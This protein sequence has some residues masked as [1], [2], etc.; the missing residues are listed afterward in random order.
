MPLP[1]STRSFF[2]SS[3]KASAACA[4]ALLTAIGQAQ[5]NVC[6]NPGG[7]GTVTATGTVNTYWTPGNGTYNNASSSIPISSP[8]GASTGVALAGGD[9]V[10]LIQMQCAN[11]NTSDTS[12]YGDGNGS[13]TE[14]GS[15]LARGYTDPAGSCLAGNY[16]FVRAGSASTAASLDI[17]AETLMHTYVQANATTTTG[18]RTF[19][20]I[21]VPQYDNLTISGTVTAP[22]WNAFTGGVVAVDVATTMT[23]NGTIDVDG[24]GF[25]GAYGRARS[26]N[27][28]T[29]RYVRTD[30]AVHGVKGEGIAGTP[31]W[32]STK[33]TPDD[34][35]AAGVTDQG[36]GW[37]GYPSGSTTTGDYARGAPGNAG[38]GGNF[39]NGSSD[40]GGGGG[41]G[42]GGTGGRGGA[43]W[44]SAGYGGINAN[45]SNLAEQKWG[46][47][48]AQFSSASLARLVFGG[49]GGA[50]DN[51]NN[52]SPANSAGAAGGGIVIIHTRRLA[53]TG[54][55]S[56]R[57]GRAADNPLNDGGG[58]GGAGGSVAL[59]AVELAGGSAISVNAQGGRGANAHFDGGPANLN[60]HGTGG[61]GGGGVVVRTVAATVDVSGGTHGLTENSDGGPDGQRHGARAGNTGLN[62]L[63]TVA[64]DTTT[65]N[66][67]YRCL[68]YGDAPAS[69]GF[70]R[71]NL[72]PSPATLRIGSVTPDGDASAESALSSSNALID[73]TSG[74]NDES[75]VSFPGS[76]TASGVYTVTVPFTN[77]TGVAATVC[78]WV[79]FDKNGTFDTDERACGT[80]SSGGTS[81]AL[82]FIVPI[83]DRGNTGTFF[84]RFRL[85]NLSTQ[86][87]SPTGLASSGEVEDYQISITTLPVTLASVSSK[88]TGDSVRVEWTTA[89]ETRNAGFHIYGRGA[90]QTDWYR[91]TDDLIPSP[92]IDSLDPQRYVW[93]AQDLGSQELLIEDWDSRGTAREHGPF[94]I[95]QRYGQD[96]DEAAAKID[97]AAIRFKNSRELEERVAQAGAAKGLG[98]EVVLWVAQPGI[99]RVTF[100]DLAAAGVRLGESKVQELAVT[101]NGQPVVRFVD[102]ANR[103]GV[104]DSGDSVEFVGRVTP[105]L[106]SNR[107]A[108]RLEPSTDKVR[109][110][111][112]RQ[113]SARWVETSVFDHRVTVEQQRTYTFAAPGADPWYDERLLATSSPV[114]LERTF[115]LPGYAGGDAELSIAVW[116]LT[117]WEGR[118]DHHLIVEVAGVEVADVRFDG[119]SSPI[120][121]AKIPA[122]LLS[123]SNN[124]L[125]LRVP[126]DTGFPYD[127]QALD[128]FWIDYSRFSEAYAGEWQGTVNT[129]DPVLV[130]G[131][132]AGDAVAWNGAQR[133]TGAREIVVS[134][135]GL[136]IAADSEGIRR[137]EVALHYKSTALPARGSVDYLIIS[138]H[139]FLNS[140]S[141]RALV[142]LQ[143]S[144]GYGTSVVD[145]AGIYAAYSDFEADAGAIRRAI[146]TVQPKY[147]LLV[148]A[149]SFDY[150]DYL[151]LGSQS[152]VPTQYVRTG[153]VVTYAPADNM[154]ADFNDDGIPEVAIG[155]LP[156]RTSDEL[157]RLVSKLRTWLPPVQ[158]VFAS[159]PSDAARQLA[160]A[161]ESFAE[162][163][164][165]ALSVVPVAVDDLG[166]DL[167]RSVLL[168]ELDQE[169][170]L[171]SYVGHS[172][173]GIWGLNPNSGILLKTEDVRGAWNP[174]PHLVTQWGCWNTYFVDPR[175]DTLAN[176]FLLQESGAAAVM[177]ATALTNSFALQELGVAFMQ[178][179]AQGQTLG[180]T[181]RLALRD[182]VRA[183]PQSAESLRGFVLLGDPAAE[184][185]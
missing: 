109:E 170:R 122:F 145:V 53:G 32:L 157:S 50:A 128:R 71:H 161:N 38:G 159:G 174:S 59:V 10:L 75:G 175:R 164:A 166:F 179:Y 22:A 185:R 7:S 155:R 61:G 21:R 29:I 150:H 62:T 105:T 11:I 151:G 23:L 116:G 95:G 114:Q 70:G 125:T 120:I 8:R 152:F 6:A 36:A 86:V 147:V 14:L 156:V 76:S 3:P 15:P 149:D 88:R 133:R 178:R 141:M 148:G 106:Y 18:R 35:N 81:V 2:S 42:N 27:D 121:E 67:G 64:S 144:R 52:S 24:L 111:A 9:L 56:A 89:T 134:G 146:Q 44:R 72:G 17:S 104:F 79:D 20:V 37:G 57:G 45:F 132:G 31:R 63:V 180:Q 96:A 110:A 12:A 119:F 39:W 99:Q 98:A 85:A 40:N 33:R 19:Q 153:S 163:L 140:A 92:V 69:Y 172:S 136:W 77:S 142:G 48:G 30:D 41:G 102:D 107:N 51:N 171:V 127:I 65:P 13:S 94:V 118:N 176:A 103:N 113:L 101:D 137:P 177:G 93:N 135:R 60:A 49:G 167:S 184:L 5:A 173:F 73:N 130:T 181:F 25:H 131:F 28:A 158:G 129:T 97:W 138:H 4:I 54:T 100:D 55:I 66:A 83:A 168:D 74:T 117:D 26:T 108:Y 43:G 16:E 160:E 58:G 80:A 126:G 183:N 90:G 68:D 46:F 139:Q 82:A 124:R 34:G 154:L 169:A 115:S 123:E 143:K 1:T 47:G 162:G 182:R 91:L 84:S 165:G 78:G 87:Q 112:S